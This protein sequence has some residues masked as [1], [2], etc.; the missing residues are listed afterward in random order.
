MLFHSWQVQGQNKSME[1]HPW[2]VQ[3]RSRTRVAI[4]LTL[5]GCVGVISQHPDCKC[6]TDGN[7][8]TMQFQNSIHHVVFPLWF[9]RIRTKL[10]K[11]L[12]HPCEGFAVE[13]SVVSPS[14]CFRKLF[15]NG[16]LQAYHVDSLGVRVTG[17][18]VFI[19]CPVLTIA[20]L[21]HHP[22]PD[23]GHH[24]SSGFV[25]VCSRPYMLRTQNGLNPA[26]AFYKVV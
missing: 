20:C 24:L 3:D 10:A 16:S 15:Y 13:F 4:L 12:I 17:L 22:S 21:G 5:V 25:L 11:F 2:Q 6:L 14:F 19:L 23:F 18:V 8:Q 9:Q 1:L 7:L 26:P